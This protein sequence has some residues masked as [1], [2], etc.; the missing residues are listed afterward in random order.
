MEAI[1]HAE[2]MMDSSPRRE[3][4]T[5]PVTE[6][7][8]PRSTTFFHSARDSSPTAARD[9]MTWRRTASPSAPDSCRVAKQ[10]LPV[11]RRKT[12]RPV[13]DTVSPEVQSGSWPSNRSRTSASAWVRGTCTG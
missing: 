8:S 13:T 10:S 9:T 2:A 7:K 5:S 12:T 4:I 3:T 1:S 11:L 6:R